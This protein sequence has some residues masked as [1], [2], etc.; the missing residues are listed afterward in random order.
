M[1]TQETASVLG[2]SRFAVLRRIRAGTIPATSYGRK[3]R[4]VIDPN[5][6]LLSVAP[7]Q[8]DRVV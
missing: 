2:I 3:G 4:Y 8:P 7:R 5:L 1:T 6:L